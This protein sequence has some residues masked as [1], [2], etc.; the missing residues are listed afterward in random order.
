MPWVVTAC[1][2]MRTPLVTNG[3]RVSSKERFDDVSPIDESV[4]DETMW[5]STE[6]GWDMAERLAHEEGLMV[7]HSSG[8]NVA[9]ALRVGKTLAAEHKPGVVVTILCD[10]GDRYFLPLKWEKHYLW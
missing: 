8:G 3:E 5:M 6:E 9:A 1:V 2:P 4:L 7:G 10:R